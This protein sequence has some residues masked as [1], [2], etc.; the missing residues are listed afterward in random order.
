M[1]PQRNRFKTNNNLNLGE[2]PDL[3]I[4]FKNLSLKKSANQKFKTFVKYL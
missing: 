2:N 3:P 1:K 4:D